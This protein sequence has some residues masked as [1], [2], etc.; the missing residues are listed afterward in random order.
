MMADPPI[1]EILDA[2]TRFLGGLAAAPAGRD[3]YMTRVAANALSIVRR[4]LTLAARADREEV[5]RLR[6]LIGQDGGL[7]ALDAALC[8]ALR[9]GRLDEMTPGLLEH[10]KRSALARVE[11]DQPRY[12]SPSPAWR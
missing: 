11:I 1:D 7:E 12:R 5:E 4:E 6:T 8:E 9:A 3:A 10:L 2:V